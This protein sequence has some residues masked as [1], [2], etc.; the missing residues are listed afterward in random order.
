MQKIQS[1]TVAIKE[2]WNY[3]S[4]VLHVWFLASSLSIVV[5]LV[6]FCLV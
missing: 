3:Q 5:M 2:V 4:P 6:V 1:A